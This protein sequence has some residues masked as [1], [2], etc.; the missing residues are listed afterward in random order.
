[1]LRRD[2]PRI[3]REPLVCANG[4]AC[5]C[6][7]RIALALR[8]EQTPPVGAGLRKIDDLG[9]GSPPALDPPG[10]LAPSFGSPDET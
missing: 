6:H 1:M 9:G 5:P 4:G 2:T 7:I 10:A 3:D 8:L